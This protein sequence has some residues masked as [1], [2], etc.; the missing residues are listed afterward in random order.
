MLP[1]RN[2]VILTAKPTMVKDPAPLLAAPSIGGATATGAVRGWAA[3]LMCL[4][5]CIPRAS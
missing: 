1:K 2:H 5:R 4:F 3:R